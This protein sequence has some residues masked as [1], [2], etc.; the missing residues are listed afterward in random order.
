M[1]QAVQRH[2]NRFL[3]SLSPADLGILS[4]ELESVDLPLGKVLC[5]PGGAFEYVYF[6]TSGM[7][8]LVTVMA[9]GHEIETGI[10]GREGVACSAVVGR[11]HSND[12][13]MVQAAGAGSRLPCAAFLSLYDRSQPF[14]EL[15]NN[16]N[17]VLWAMAQ[18]TAACNVLHPLE[19]RLARWLL[20]TRDL[21]ES[22]EIRLTQEFL[23][24]ML[25]VQRTTVTL[26]EGRLQ[27]ENL[28]TVRRGRIRLMDVPGLKRRACECYQT[29]THQR[30]PPPSPKLEDG[31]PSLY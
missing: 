9:N 31:G 17:V 15:T 4:L 24:I 13:Q 20:Q 11:T 10:V 16:Y 30:P 14:R 7:I 18:Q 12:K 5:S 25:G 27:N 1:D 8:S 28:I 21:L 26:A 3:N 23:S 19:A 29:L 2:P 6:P 22:D